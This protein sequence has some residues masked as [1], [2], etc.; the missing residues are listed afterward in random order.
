MEPPLELYF[1]LRCAYCHEPA[2]AVE[3]KLE[4]GAGEE[5][6]ED[7]HLFEDLEE[8]SK[9]PSLSRERD[10]CCAVD[11]ELQ[12]YP[13]ISVEEVNRYTESGSRAR[14]YLINSYNQLFHVSLYFLMRTV[15]TGN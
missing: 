14:D 12:E 2:T 8:T 1:P 15:Y 4:A 3:M 7:E 6:S 10:P 5:R 11:R 9:Q 13:E